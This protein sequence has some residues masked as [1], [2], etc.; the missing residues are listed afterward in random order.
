MDAGGGC[1]VWFGLF[2]ITDLCPILVTFPVVVVKYP[3][4][5]NVENGFV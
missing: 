5:D 2:V 1:L 4:K 3:E